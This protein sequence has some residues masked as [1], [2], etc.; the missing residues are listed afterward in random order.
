MAVFSTEKSMQK[1]TENVLKN[2]VTRSF[3]VSTPAKM[4]YRDECLFTKQYIEKIR[5]VVGGA[6]YYKNIQNIHVRL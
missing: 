3:Y 1:N 2:R 6:K 4:V 5:E